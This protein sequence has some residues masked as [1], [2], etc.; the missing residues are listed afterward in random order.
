MDAIVEAEPLSRTQMA[1]RVAADIPEGWTVNLGI[2]IPTMVA[3]HVPADR[4]V[5][6]QSENG[7]I[8]VGP[9]P[10]KDAVASSIAA[11][12]TIVGTSTARRTAGGRPHAPRRHGIRRARKAVGTMQTTTLRTAC[13]GGMP[14]RWRR[15]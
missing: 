7:V 12:P 15:A 4:E 14:R 3:D 9:A 2:G 8:G 6:F 11:R 1:A 5:I 13:V 10:A